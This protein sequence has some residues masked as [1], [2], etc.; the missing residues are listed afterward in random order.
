LTDLYWLNEVPSDW[1]ER[2]SHLES[3]RDI[4]AEIQDLAN[5]RLNFVLTNFLDASVRRVVAPRPDGVAT[6]P[7]RLAILSS[8]TVSHLPSGIRT[9][10]WRRGIWIDTYE[11]AFGQYHQELVDRSSGLHSFEPNVILFAFDAA[12]LLA[13]LSE[14]DGY[15]ALR[16]AKERTTNMWKLARTEFD[17]QIIQQAVLPIALPLLGQ[18]EQRL[19]WSGV[20][21]I[22][23]LNHS[24]RPL[25]DGEGIQLLSVDLRAGV[26]GVGKWHD[27]ALW[28]RSK[29]EISPV[30]SPLYGDLV[31]R[32]LAAL[33]G[34]S[35]KCLVLDLDNTI[36]GGVIGDDGLDGIVIGQGSALGEAYLALQTYA[37]DLARRGVILAVCS[38][39][40]IENAVE[41][42]EKHP[43]M[44]LKLKDIGCFVANWSDKPTNLR[45][46]AAELNIGLDSLVFL[47][48]NPFE[49]E[50]VR[51][52]LPMIA[53]PEV[54]DDPVSYAQTISDAGY[55]EAL[56]ITT[57]DLERT[58]LY[59]TNRLRQSALASS[60]DLDSYLKSLEMRLI[61]SHF[62]E[63]GLQRIVQLINKSNQFN[64]TTRR[65]TADEVMLVINDPTAVGL[66]L[67]LID[68]FGDN[69]VIGIVI[70]RVTGQNLYLDTWIMSCRV[71]GRQVEQ[72]TVSIIV[73]EAMRLGVDWVVGEYIPSPKNSMVQRHYPN[74]GFSISLETE[75]GRNTSALA[76]SQ[77]KQTPTFID[78]VKG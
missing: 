72:A 15:E 22:E 7:V 18:N 23:E 32:L 20:T 10:C 64:L 13:G 19:A 16:Q 36:W 6:K 27:P 76:V 12:H 49:R 3:A 66:Q 39:N 43:D 77:Y 56:A 46:V 8:S 35:R 37:R 70:G 31:G 25:A 34:R 60:T 58:E 24:L 4:W 48:D 59:Q 69:G 71:L 26:D 65:Y 53:V 68:R 2:A 52:T 55:F 45:A 17:C 33:Q 57:E 14:G 51:R 54:T 74:L 5:A 42:F 61:W 28:H 50:L 9:G 29:Q 63:V 78:I 21:F 30:V 75:D 67:R 40:D 73:S 1:R 11:V 47:D 38:K 62:D 44:L 41:P